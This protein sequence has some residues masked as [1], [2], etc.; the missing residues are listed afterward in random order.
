A[1]EVFGCVVDECAG[2]TFPVD[3]WSLGVTLYEILA[4][5]RPFD[6]HSATTI[7]EVRS[8]FTS[9]VHYSPKWTSVVVDLL[10]RLLCVAPGARLSSL[11]ELKKV[12][13]FKSVDF[14]AIFEKQIKPP[15]TPPRDHLNCDPTF[16]LEE[17]IVEAKPLHKKKK[18][19]AKQR[20]LRG[21]LSVEMPECEIESQ[22]SKF[23]TYN[24]EKELVRREMEMKEN[25]WEQE[26]LQAMNASSNTEEDSIKTNN[27]LDL[28]VCQERRRSSCKLTVSPMS[29][30]AR[31][32]ASSN[33]ATSNQNVSS[34]SLANQSLSASRS[35]AN[36]N[37]SSSS[38]ANQSSLNFTTEASSTLQ[39]SPGRRSKSPL[40]GKMP[41]AK[42]TAQVLIQ[43]I[44]SI[45]IFENSG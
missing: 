11:D 5:A 45:Q 9:P 22:L 13:Y 3:W 12:P 39:P 38:I 19:L 30:Q 8:L 20:S 23:H 27:L 6:I 17:M 18:R 28:P 37:S 2:Y 26:L 29:V 1:P 10:S 35:Q 40:R 16:E 44:P 21:S 14:D 7:P 43:S 4:R 36:Q 25:A 24:R 41:P 32:A 42:N 34:S 33:L 31:L 15:F